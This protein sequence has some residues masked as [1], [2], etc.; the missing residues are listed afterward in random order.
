MTSSRNIAP[1]SLLAH[2]LALVLVAAL[3]LV[4]S[5]CG[6]EE[7]TPEARIEALIAE[8]EQAAESRDVPA[9][10]ALVSDH[11]Q[12]PRGYDRR[13]VLR[14][15]Q[16]LFLRNQSIHV[17]TVVRDL[18]VAGDTASVRVL[19]AMAGRPIESVEALVNV[20]ADLMRFDLELARE[21]GDWLVRSADWR[22]AELSDFL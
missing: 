3:A 17:L 18:R 10:G 1:V 12:D 5:A 6:G 11:Y 16:G 13:T 22:R 20:R 8:G 21:D 4:L 2:A 14:I 9:L 7:Q 15:A 19:A